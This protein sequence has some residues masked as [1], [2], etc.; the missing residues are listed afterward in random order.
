MR[1]LAVALLALG[2]AAPAVAVPLASTRR[3]AR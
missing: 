2:L 3:C 1:R